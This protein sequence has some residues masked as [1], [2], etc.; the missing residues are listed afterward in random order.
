MINGISINQF[1][2]NKTYAAESEAYNLYCQYAYIPR[3]LR[4]GYYVEYK[5]NPDAIKE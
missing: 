4:L 2:L 1:F 3:G 5:I